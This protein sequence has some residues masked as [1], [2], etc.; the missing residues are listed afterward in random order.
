[1][2]KNK[3]QFTI[4][5]I[6]TPEGYLFDSLIEENN[7]PIKSKK[8][9]NSSLKNPPN[10]SLNRIAKELALNLQPP[11]IH[12][13]QPSLPHDELSMPKNPPEY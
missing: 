10:R 1:M 12:E 4:N 7:L 3:T 6:K 9:K 11:P 8:V 13:E 2:K 5:L